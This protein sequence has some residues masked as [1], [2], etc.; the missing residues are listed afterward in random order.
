MQ[1]N[2]EVEKSW[3]QWRAF[4]N[5]NKISGN[6]VKY[7]GLTFCTFKGVGHMVPEWKPKDAFYIFSKFM[8]NEDF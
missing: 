5:N 3:R 7:K 2:L 4:G 6:Y 1:L 8:N